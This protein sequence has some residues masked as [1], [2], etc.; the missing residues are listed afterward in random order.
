MMKESAAYFSSFFLCFFVVRER[1]AWGSFVRSF[2]R[3]TKAWMFLFPREREAEE[4]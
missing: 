1:E 2:V 4:Q 3:P